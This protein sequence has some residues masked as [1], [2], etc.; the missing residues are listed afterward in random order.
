M[1]PEIIWLTGQTGSGK[2]TMLKKMAGKDTILLDGDN[3][4][5]VWPGLTM[6][7]MD[8]WEQNLRTA[9]LARM[10]AD[11]GFCVVVATIA[12]FEKLR[13]EIRTITGCSFI[14]IDHN[15][16]PNDPDRPYEDAWDAEMIVRRK[17]DE[18]ALAERRPIPRNKEVPPDA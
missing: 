12:P 8:R 1:S 18:V 6:S 16:Y 17:V 15:E 10:L 2:T 9:R 14:F 4:R 5:A 7:R 3:L 13:R 11:Q